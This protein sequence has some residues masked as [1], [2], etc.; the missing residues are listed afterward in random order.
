M[1]ATLLAINEHVH[2]ELSDIPADGVVPSFQPGDYPVL[3]VGDGR[4]RGRLRPPR[5]PGHLRALRPRRR[6]PRR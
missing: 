5:R 1:T 2:W 4:T 6:P 3:T